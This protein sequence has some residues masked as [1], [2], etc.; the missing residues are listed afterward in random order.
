MDE[1]SGDSIPAGSGRSQDEKM[2]VVEVS[3]GRNE[4]NKV[5]SEK[6]HVATKGSEDSSAEAP[7]DTGAFCERVED[8]K[9]KKGDRM[10][11]S[12][13]DGQNQADL[14]GADQRNKH[15]M[16]SLGKLGT[17]RLFEDGIW[18]DDDQDEMAQTI[19]ETATYMFPPKFTLRGV[20]EKVS[21]ASCLLD[22][23]YSELFIARKSSLLESTFS[24]HLQDFP[25]ADWK[26]DLW[27]IEGSNPIN[28]SLDWYGHNDLPAHDMKRLQKAVVLSAA[29]CETKIQ[30]L[31]WNG[32][33]KPFLSYFGRKLRQFIMFVQEDGAG[34]G[35]TDHEHEEAITILNGRHAIML[36]WVA[37][38]IAYGSKITFRDYL[39]KLCSEESTSY[40]DICEET[41]YPK[42]LLFSFYRAASL[43][44]PYMTANNSIGDVS[45]KRLL[46]TY[47]NDYTTISKL[48]ETNATHAYRISDTTIQPSSSDTF[49][50]QELSLPSI[51]KSTDLQVIW[52]ED[53]SNHLFI[54]QK[55]EGNVLCLY[56]P[57][58]TGMEFSQLTR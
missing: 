32:F 2:D 3:N 18:I 17:M 30:P 25:D 47:L 16:K 43:I 57:C 50:H 41:G 1:H 26:E 38:D 54:G 27:A 5:Y 19:S 11:S 55:D 39:K 40:C 20:E 4:E 6:S 48:F 36:C 37:I 51:L 15:S 31:T 22:A 9:T 53:L 28:E 49:Q 8:D 21:N 23:D 14:R 42:H 33:A 44:C 10:T 13:R 56:W 35:P 46:D 45:T 7:A 58:H 29:A 52:C 12:T 34:L 24:L